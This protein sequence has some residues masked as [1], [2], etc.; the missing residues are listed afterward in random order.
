[1]NVWACDRFSNSLVLGPHDGLDI[2][3]VDRKEKQTASNCIY[4]HGGS[5]EVY[6]S[7]KKGASGKVA[8]QLLAALLIIPLVRRL[9]E[10]MTHGTLNGQIKI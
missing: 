4:F 1:M 9:S 10:F 6:P 2:T 8:S 7:L 5:A 3:I